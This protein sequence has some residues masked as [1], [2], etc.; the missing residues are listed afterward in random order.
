VPSSTA[1][2]I[3]S[4]VG[5]GE[6]AVEGGLEVDDGA[7]DAAFQAAPGQP[8]EEALDRIEPGA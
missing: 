5:L 7:E 6:E 8:G 1:P 2:M 3:L 4:G